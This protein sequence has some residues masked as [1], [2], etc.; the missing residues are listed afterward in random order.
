MPRCKEVNDLAADFDG[1]V[2][3]TLAAYR[4]TGT[5]SVGRSQRSA[6]AARLKSQLPAN[7]EGK[8]D[9]ACGSTGGS[10]AEPIGPTSTRM[11][12]TRR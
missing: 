8:R 6:A 9:R 11:E 4:R 3:K 7:R 2:S 10:R 1:R 5:R 12:T